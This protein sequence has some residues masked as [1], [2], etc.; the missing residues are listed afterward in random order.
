MRKLLLAAASLALIAGPVVAFAATKPMAAKTPAAAPGTNRMAVCG[1]KWS[2]LGASGQ[3][4]Y[5][6]QA[7][8]QKGK[9]G[10]ALSGYNLFSKS[11]LSGK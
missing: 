2:A 4:T 11:C 8:G 1:A 10:R 9:S 6:A 3:A 7:K 5:D